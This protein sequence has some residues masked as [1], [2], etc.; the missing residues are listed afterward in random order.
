MFPLS[1][2]SNRILVRAWEIFMLWRVMINRRVEAM[3]CFGWIWN[4]RL[5][6]LMHVFT[7][8][9]L[10]N[11]QKIHLH[12]YYFWVF[13]CIL[14]VLANLMDHGGHAS[15]VDY[16]GQVFIP[17]LNITFP[18]WSAFYCTIAQITYLQDQAQK[19]NAVWQREKMILGLLFLSVN[20]IGKWLYDVDWGRMS[21]KSFNCRGFNF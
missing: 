10:K 15:F 13:I 16:D 11:K 1:F 21:T 19:H 8:L 2:L 7:E 9:E 5:K 12:I 20:A 14:K 17:I 4:F 3:T 6:L 18:F